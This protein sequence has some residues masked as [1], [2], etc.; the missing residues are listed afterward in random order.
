[1]WDPQGADPV[2]DMPLGTRIWSQST[3]LKMSSRTC[4][5]LSP[6][7][8]TPQSPHPPNRPPGHMLQT[9][10]QNEGRIHRH[11]ESHPRVA[12]QRDSS[13][14]TERWD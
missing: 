3:Q 10:P 14:E 7:S 9:D 11:I 13:G 5:S 1:M 12:G 4:A 6:A 8:T 2:V